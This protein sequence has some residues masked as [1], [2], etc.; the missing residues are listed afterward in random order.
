M[1]HK[2]SDIYKI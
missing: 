1:T 2:Q